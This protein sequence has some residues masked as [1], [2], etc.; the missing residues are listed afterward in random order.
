MEE[1]RKSSASLDDVLE[2]TKGTDLR[3]ILGILCSMD[4]KEIENLDPIPAG[5]KYVGNLTEIEKAHL[6]MICRLD[7]KLKDLEASVRDRD[8]L[9]Q[10]T[11]FI[12]KMLK[13]SMLS[14]CENLWIMVHKRFAHLSTYDYPIR[15][16][17]SSTEV[18]IDPRSEME[19]ELKAEMEEKI[20]SDIESGRCP[21]K[22]TLVIAGEVILY[23][24]MTEEELALAM[25]KQILKHL[26]EE[27]KKFLSENKNE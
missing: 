5:A 26:S 21:I 18:F 27:T 17:Y 11:I 10:G 2:M 7:K 1:K 24:G 8:I 20:K 13:M 12:G 14:T 9:S 22:D 19:M 15:Y 6:V 4:F 23:P 16:L 3:E 25:S